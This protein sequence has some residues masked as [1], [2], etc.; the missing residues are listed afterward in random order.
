MP[1]ASRE[2]RVRGLELVQLRLEMSAVV[3]E[4]QLLIAESR[5]LIVEAY[6]SLG[7]AIGIESSSRHFVLA[8]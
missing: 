4:Y 5:D 3:D 8:C 1:Y 2:K 7:D 6:R